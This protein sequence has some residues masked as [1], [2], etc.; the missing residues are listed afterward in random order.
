MKH[1]LIVDDNTT[2]LKVES[3]MLQGRYEV[4]MA[5]SGKQ[6]LSFLKKYTPDL[7]LLDI[8]MPEM[9]GYETM[10][11]I[12]LN[13]LTANI[14]IIF[15]TAD[16]ERES[17]IKGLSLGA[18][19]F[20]TKPFEE[21]VVLGRIEKVL[22]MDDMRKGLLEEIGTSSDNGLFSVDALKNKTKELIDNN[23]DGALILISFTNYRDLREKVNSNILSSYFSTVCDYLRQDNFKYGIASKIFDD[24]YMILHTGQ[25]DIRELQYCLN[26]IAINLS[27]EI[28][29]D[30]TTISPIIN[31]GSSM[32]GDSLSFEEIYSQADKALY[33]ATMSDNINTHIYKSI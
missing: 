4:S 6:A 7:I 22:A 13:P 27:G 24:L 12:K 1:I 28:E 30:N 18:L 23:S 32:L 33:H 9:N 29:L 26:D 11:E 17:E 20:I 2:N 31:I 16:K 8:L 3:Q 19:D 21:E 15:L 10:E 5:K 25:P 14:P